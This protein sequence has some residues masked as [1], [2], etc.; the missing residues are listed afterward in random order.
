MHYRTSAIY[1]DF[2]FRSRERKI[3]NFRAIFK[4]IDHFFSTKDVSRSGK[5]ETGWSEG[6]WEKITV[7]FLRWV[8]W[9]W[10]YG[11]NEQ[12]TNTRKSVPPSKQSHEDPGSE[13]TRPE[14][15]LEIDGGVPLKPVL[16]ERQTAII[17]RRIRKDNHPCSRNS[18]L[19]SF[20]KNRLVYQK[21]SPPS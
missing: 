9:W 3:Y 18:R 20:L 15:F 17:R 21:P 19:I 11:T 10:P 12:T 8:D 6:V 4:A 16:L 5:G 13:K 14:S 2:C 7:L 1:R